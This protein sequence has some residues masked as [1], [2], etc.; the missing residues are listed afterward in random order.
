LKRPSFLPLFLGFALL[1]SIAATAAAQAKAVTIPKGT[2]VEKL[3]PGS[4]KLT[5]PDGAVF[6]ITSYKKAGKGQGAPVGAV[7]IL[8][9]CGIRDARG[10]LIATGAG[11]VLKGGVRSIIG[12]SGKALKDIP[13]GDYIKI[14]DEV[15]WLPATIQ[16][17]TLRIFNRQAVVKL[18]PQPDP[19]GKQR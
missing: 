3:G 5:T 11:G 13:P 4:F 19:P 16:F 8:G 10:K 15:T 17:A 1:L 2:K 6:T 7:G 12:D 14:D 9:D 18:S